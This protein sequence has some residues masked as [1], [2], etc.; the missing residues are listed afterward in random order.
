V[1]ET[2][3]AVVLADLSELITDGDHRPPKRVPSGI[4][5][6]T[7][8]NVRGGRFDFTGCSFVTEEGFAQTRSRYEPLA[9]DVIVTCVGTIG[10]VA[11]V[12]QGLT[13]SADRN[14]AAVRPKDGIDADYVRVVL[15]SPG[16]QRRIGNASG[17]TAQPHLY[18]RDLRAIVVPIPPVEE[19][20]RI[21]AE[22]E[23]QM[24]FI[25]ACERSIGAGLDLSSGL[26]R[27]VLKAAFEGRLVPQDPSDEPASILLERIRADRAAN[28]KP[29]KRRARS[30]A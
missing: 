17:S 14:L 1:P 26:R 12:P 11:V 13:F 3:T 2:W 5:H 6:L 30:T 24:S 28:P 9:G 20:R 22:V 16:V 4:P 8:K 15:E 7:A 19:Q 21:V 18:L 27:S 23:R 25:D 10:R 29:K